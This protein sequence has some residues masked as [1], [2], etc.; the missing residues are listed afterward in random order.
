MHASA[1]DIRDIG[2]ES[3]FL[4]AG[5][6]AILLQIAHPAVGAGVAEHSDFAH[7]ALGRLHG[8]L[9]YLY[10]LEYGTDADRRAVQRIVNRAHAPVRGP[11]YSAFDP[12]LQRW[13]AAT[14]HQ[15]ML[16]LY[17]GAFG[18]LSNA[19]ADEIQRRQAQVGT[20]LQMPGELWP[21]TRDAFDRYW[22]GSL[23]ALRVTPDARR[24]ARDLLAARESPWWVR[25]LM[26]YIRLVTA[27]L[28]PPELRE[29]FGF[30][31]DA[32][33]QRRFDRAMGATFALYRVLPQRIRTLPCTLYLRRLRRSS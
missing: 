31:W 30:R 23:A 33:Q 3:I 22:A 9:T 15:S 32:R 19:D 16:E 27:G 26:P 12:E 5:G 6:R 1:R 7:R 17:E 21:Q 11:G 29:P 28:L 20:S 4:V 8:T 10:A 18:A 2:R 13:V 14:I 25:A 24:V